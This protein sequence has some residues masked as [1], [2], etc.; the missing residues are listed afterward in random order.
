MRIQTLKKSNQLEIYR[1][2][3]LKKPTNACSIIQKTNANLMDCH[4]HISNPGNQ[5]YPK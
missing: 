2:N 4:I 1:V 3:Q 5:I